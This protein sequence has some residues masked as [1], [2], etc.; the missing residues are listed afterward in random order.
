MKNQHTL[1]I[2]Q[3]AEGKG[4]VGVGGRLVCIKINLKNKGWRVRI[5]F[6]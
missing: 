1:K 3:A 5:R 4:D 6:I 2:L